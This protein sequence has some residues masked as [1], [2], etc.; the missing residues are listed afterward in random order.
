MGCDDT[1]TTGYFTKDSGDRREFNSG[2]VRDRGDLKERFYL[3]TPL[4]VPY[5]HQML[6]RLAGLMARGAEKYD[7]RNWE[8][9]NSSDELDEFIESAAR[10]FVKWMTGVDDGEDHAAAVWFNIQG[11]EMVK[12]KI[13]QGWE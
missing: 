4:E 11:A 2:M 3:I 5:E 1:D 10:H 12:Y 7:D 13:K 9:A 8:L 6:T